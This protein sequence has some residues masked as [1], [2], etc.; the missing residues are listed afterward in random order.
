M[1]E[2]D[3]NLRTMKTFHSFLNFKSSTVLTAIVVLLLCLDLSMAKFTPLEIDNHPCTAE[4]LKQTTKYICDN[5]GNVICQSGWK[6]SEPEDPLNPCSEPICHGEAGCENGMCRA[7][8]YCACEV[9]WEGARCEICIPLPGSNKELVIMLWNV[10]VRTNG[11]VLIVKYLIVTIVKKTVPK[12][13]GVWNPMSASVLMA[14]LVQIVPNVCQWQVAYME[15]V[16]NIPILV[17][18]KQI[19]K[20]IFV[21]NQFALLDVSMVNVLKAL[22]ILLLEFLKTIF[23]FVKL[24]GARQLV[25]YQFAIGNVRL[26]VE[27]V[28]NQINVIVLKP[29]PFVKIR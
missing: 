14:G 12:L 10:I 1:G 2:C 8:D 16:V 27:L 4:K 18:A 15:I 13:V 11:L 9:G 29:I 17:N 7:P 22:L 23:A 3:P 20:D 21:I 6:N 26:W 28:P 5:D 25:M 19:L 24:D